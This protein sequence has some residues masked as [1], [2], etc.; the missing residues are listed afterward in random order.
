MDLFGWLFVTLFCLIIWIIFLTILGAL[1]APFILII[2][3]IFY[4][5]FNKRKEIRLS[6]E[7]KEI[8]FSVPSI[9]HHK[10]VILEGAKKQGFSI[11]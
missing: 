5:A 7:G 11:H 6:K 10:K 9:G 2:G 1:F 8:V 4:K 3:F